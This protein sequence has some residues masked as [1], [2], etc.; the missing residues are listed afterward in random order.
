MRLHQEPH[1][2]AA[3][4]PAPL[5]PRGPRWEGEGEGRQ[6]G[7]QGL[8]RLQCS[9]RSLPSPTSGG[10]GSCLPQEHGSAPPPLCGGDKGGVGKGEEQRP[11][12]WHQ[13]QA[14]NSLPS[15][16]KSRS[17][18]DRL[19]ILLYPTARQRDRATGRE[20][21]VSLSI[22]YPSGTFRRPEGGLART[23]G[24][25]AHL[26]LLPALGSRLAHKTGLAGQQE[27]AGREW[28]GGGVPAWSQGHGRQG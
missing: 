14:S 8:G 25:P 27:E 21:R 26:L 16:G 1:P 22:F 5:N 12:S 24:S 6:R 20:A 3:R 9:A 17:E 7:N 4:S 23:D 11:H 2:V 18:G 13:T 15:S 10:G 28:R 19:L